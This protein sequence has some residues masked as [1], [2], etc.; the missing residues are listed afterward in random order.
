M[1]HI[2]F[3]ARTLKFFVDSGCVASKTFFCAGYGVLVFQNLEMQEGG[4]GKENLV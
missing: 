4:G 3:V 2:V 1:R